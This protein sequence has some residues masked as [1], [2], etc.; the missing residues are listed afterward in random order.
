MEGFILMLIKYFFMI[1]QMLLCVRE[2]SSYDIHNHF[3]LQRQFGSGHGQKVDDSESGLEVALEYHICFLHR[4]E[5]FSSQIAGYEFYNFTLINTSFTSKLLLLQEL[6]I[7]LL[8]G[9]ILSIVPVYSGSITVGTE[10]GSGPDSQIVYIDS[11]L[12]PFHAG[13][14]G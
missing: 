4:S 13:H 11:A 1:Q 8:E 5:L 7:K 2:R 14:L 9:L 10:A 3:L 6:V 12:H